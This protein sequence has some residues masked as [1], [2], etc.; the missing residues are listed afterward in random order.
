MRM[1]WMN[2]VGAIVKTAFSTE[3]GRK[4]I[5]TFGDTPNKS[6]RVEPIHG[7]H[8]SCR[9]IARIIDRIIIEV[10]DFLIQPLQ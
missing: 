9:L 5:L 7:G 2:S 3:I 10:G 6:R 4:R 8:S 1:G